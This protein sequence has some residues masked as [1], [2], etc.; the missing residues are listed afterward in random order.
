MG[1]HHTAGTGHAQHP[2]NQR[3]DGLDRLAIGRENQEGR[4]A[5][6]RSNTCE[7]SRLLAEIPRRSGEPMVVGEAW[8]LAIM[9]VLVLGTLGLLVLLQRWFGL[10]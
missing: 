10:T 9:F 4:H 8:E 1:G 5:C 7:S 2:H 3:G 6:S